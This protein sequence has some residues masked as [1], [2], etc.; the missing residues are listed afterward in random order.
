MHE[1]IINVC[2]AEMN[3]EQFN[4]D[5]KSCDLCDGLNSEKLGTQNAPGYG[6]RNSKVVLI[7]Q[8]LCGKPCIEA[9]IPFTGG[10][11]KLLDK[12]FQ[13]A[14]I[15]KRDIY[16]TN[17]VKCHP[18]NNR[19]STEHEISNCSPYLKQELKWIAPLHIICLGKDAWAF[20]NASISS[21]CEKEVKMY[22]GI[23][24]IHF[25]YHPSYIKRKPQKDQETYINTIANIIRQCSA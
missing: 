23:T 12:A 10:S 11:G 15:N 6:N 24:K 13:N 18:P 1:K 7:G 17:V 9:Q 8:S 16:I 5:I 25:V 2:S 4:S 20:F 14:G 3:W 19:K 21:P 22:G